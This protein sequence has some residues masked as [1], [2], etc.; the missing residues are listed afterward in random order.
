MIVCVC[1]SVCYNRE[2]Q[3]PLGPR[4][5]MALQDI[6]ETR[7]LR[8][9]CQYTRTHDTSDRSNAKPSLCVSGTP[10]T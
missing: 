9:V 5:K 1:V 6:E 7:V 10:G 8:Y 3:E 4:E 2:V